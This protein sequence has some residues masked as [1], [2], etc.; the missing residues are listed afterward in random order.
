MPRLDPVGASGRGV[1]PP[2]HG[3]HA[4]VLIAVLA[5]VVVATPGC[6]AGDADDV[7][8][9]VRESEFA[10]REGGS[11]AQDEAGGRDRDRARGSSP[12]AER[13]REGRNEPSSHG[14]SPNGGTEGLA[15]DSGQ[16]GPGNGQKDRKP[17]PDG[18]QAAA[19]DQG[20]PNT[21]PSG[22][23]YESDA[24]EFD[25]VSEASPPGTGGHDDTNPQP[26]VQG[27]GHDDTNPQPPVPPGGHD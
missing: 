19:P 3:R 25:G 8:S 26:P 12:G 5:G 24:A 17:Q 21:S 6:G 9:T 2:A 13:G 18:T 4:L 7:D 14:E 10:A 20:D 15:P 23:T 1:S 22:G 27:G 11:T 16:G